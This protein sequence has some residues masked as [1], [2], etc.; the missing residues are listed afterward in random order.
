MGQRADAGRE[1]H[2]IVKTAQRSGFR[3]LFVKTRKFVP[4]VVAHM[5]SGHR[6]EVETLH[7]AGRPSA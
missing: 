6:T 4:H 7:S 1:V 2:G 3:K 5:M